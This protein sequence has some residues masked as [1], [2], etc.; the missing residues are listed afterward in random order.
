MANPLG[1][2]RSKDAPYAIWEGNGF[3]WLIL[4]TYQTPQ[5]EAK[6]MYCRWFV[7]ASSPFT[8]G[9]YDMGDTYVAEVVKYGR[10]VAASPEFKQAYGI[11]FDL[12]DP[13]EY[14]RAVE[15]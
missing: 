13:V 8:F 2:S 15:A 1:K 4:K 10:L 7:A 5:N 12:A 14:L 3:R 6:N 9:G 11:E